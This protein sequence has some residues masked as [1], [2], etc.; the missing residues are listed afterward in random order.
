M[1]IQKNTLPNGLRLVT[2]ELPYAHSVGIT[3][4]LLVGSRY[5][6]E[7]LAGVSHF[8]EHMLFKGTKHYP[9]A[10]DIAVAIEGVGGQF[11]GMTT[12]ETTSYIAKVPAEHCHDILHVFADMLRFPL[13]DLVEIEKERRVIIE[14]LRA[15]YDD[16]SD[17]VEVI[18]QKKIWGDLSLGEDEGGS[19]QSVEQLT[20]ED[21]LEYY[22]HSYC[23]DRLVLSVAGPVN[24]SEILSYVTELYGDWR[25]TSSMYYQ[26]CIY[27][28][29]KDFLGFVT[30]PAEQVSLCLATPGLSYTSLDYY[31]FACMNTILGEGMSS[32][33]FQR[34]REKQSLAYEVE[35]YCNF[36]HETGSAMVSAAVEPAKVALTVQ[37]IMHELAVLCNE[38]VSNEELA[39]MKSYIRGSVLLFWESTLSVASSIGHQECFR[40]AIEQPEDIIAAFNAVTSEDIQRVAR[41]YF[42]PE[43]YRLALV[44]PVDELIVN[45]VRQL[46]PST[47]KYEEAIS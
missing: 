37:S 27:P 41:I 22:T 18:I 20:A 46:F 47:V 6:S 15:A 9:T 38:R 32:R 12:K 17:L 39:R 24:H 8:I 3:C 29:T 4:T 2:A 26:S 10:Q 7:K 21:I 5:E 35:S 40:N 28:A 14:E 45:S 36:Y 33:L 13:F 25:S 23:P 34:I 42:V 31:A 43:Q 30:K 19:L 1:N 44:G 11:N 16:P